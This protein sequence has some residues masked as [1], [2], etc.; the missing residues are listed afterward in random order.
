MT[1]QND[2]YYAPESP[3]GKRFNPLVRRIDQHEL[4]DEG[5]HP[6]PE[7]F[8][9]FQDMQRVNTFLGGTRITLQ[10]VN[11][12]TGELQ[13]GES[14]SLLDIGTGH[15]DIPR[16]ISASL[17]ERGIACRLLGADIDLA[18]IR[19][20]VQLP[21]NHQIQFIQSDILALPFADSSIDIAMCSMTLH[22]LDDAEAV[23]ALR[24]MARVARLGI[25]V[26]DLVRRTHGY[27]VA[28]L[29]GRLATSNR[30]TRHDAH[31]SILR[32]RTERELEQLALQAGLQ[33]P[34][35]D[36]TLGYRTAMTIG[37]RPW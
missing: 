11:R 5:S 10:A 19:T 27:A 16:A 7:L 33:P 4:L 20:G 29:L 28:W 35:F 17:S 26:N 25:I 34:V 9:T 37:V 8:G 30:L 21:E 2:N 32:G 36:S 1:D 31:R 22:H 23:I 12:L 24:E 13:R 3:H 15:G 18:T 14:L 6:D